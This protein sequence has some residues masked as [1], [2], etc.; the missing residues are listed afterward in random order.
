MRINYKGRTLALTP[1][2][3][4]HIFLSWF[5]HFIVTAWNTLLSLNTNQ[6]KPYTIDPSAAAA[7]NYKPMMLKSWWLSIRCGW[8]HAKP[9]DADLLCQRKQMFNLLLCLHRLEINWNIHCCY[10]CDCSLCCQTINNLDSDFERIYT[11]YIHMKY[12]ICQHIYPE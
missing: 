2:N 6:I 10:L 8:L 4:A 9:I 11:I 12:E 3:H 7:D 1:P 5:K